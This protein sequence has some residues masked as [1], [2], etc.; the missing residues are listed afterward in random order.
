MRASRAPVGG[1]QV[2]A[3]RLGQHAGVG[4]DPVLEQGIGAQTPVLLA[5]DRGQDDVT[6]QAYAAVTQG[7]RGVGDGRGASFHIAGATSD[8]S[9][10]AH[11]GTEGV[12]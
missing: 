9:I 11:I 7:S 1:D 6:G 8:E 4:G 10:A 2:Q 12:T 3:R 5:G